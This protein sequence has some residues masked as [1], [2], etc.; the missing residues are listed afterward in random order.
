MKRWP[1]RGKVN[2]EEVLAK[3]SVLVMSSGG[4]EPVTDGGEEGHSIFVRYLMD[5]LRNA[6]NW[7]IGNSLFEQVQREVRQN[8]PQ[9]P[10]Y[11]GAKSVGHQ[12]GATTFFEFR[13]LE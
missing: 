3:P 11:R 10:Q 6:N 7:Q 2:S 12:A 13:E 5:A 4:D 1:R 9:T 8:F